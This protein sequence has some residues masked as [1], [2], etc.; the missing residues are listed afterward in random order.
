MPLSEPVY[1]SRIRHRHACD[2]AAQSDAPL[3]DAIY[4][5]AAYHFADSTQADDWFAAGQPLYARDGLP[6]VRALEREVAA[7]EGADDAI[8]VASGMAAIAMTLLAHLRTGDHLLVGNDAYCESTALVQLMAHQH[9]IRVTHVDLKDRAAVLA[10]IEPQTRLILAETISNP[11]LILL[12]IPMLATLAHQQGIALAVDNTFATPVLCQP[13]RFGAD[14]VIHSAGKFLGG[15]GDVTA[16]VVAGSRERIGAIKDVAHL[17]G[18]VLAPMEAWLTSR[19]IKTLHA[20]IHQSSASALCIARWLAAHSEVA[21]V[22]YPGIADG[23]QTTLTKHLLPSGGGAILT[24]RLH[25]GHEA[26]ETFVRAIRTI[27]YVPSV[28]G[29]A[30]IVSFPPQFRSCESAHGNSWGGCDRD[31]V[32][33]SIG[34]EAPET[35]V[36]DLR[37]ALTALTTQSRQAIRSER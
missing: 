21:E 27:P 19:G 15:H 2:H 20:R 35:I 7:L 14:L 5:G 25:G 16:G 26:A 10:A 12:D 8:A 6:N 11:R 34:L 3:I 17:Y 30:T 36:A 13:L 23:D 18:P 37:Q 28:G 24:M 31:T 29:L 22:R 9:G 1:R 4:Q 32:R 33:L